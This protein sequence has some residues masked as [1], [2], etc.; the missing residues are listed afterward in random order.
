MCVA[1]RVGTTTLFL[2]GSCHRLLKIPAQAK[3]PGGIGSLQSILGL[4]KS[5]KIR[6]RAGTTTLFLL[7]SI[8]CSPLMGGWAL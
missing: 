7:G 3:Q 2:L 6:W 1:W 5:L 8:H 4:L